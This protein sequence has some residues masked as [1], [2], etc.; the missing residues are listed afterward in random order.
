MERQYLHLT[1][2]DCLNWVEKKPYDWWKLI[3][4][5]VEWVDFF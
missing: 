2:F 5:F 3:D 4:L 1:V